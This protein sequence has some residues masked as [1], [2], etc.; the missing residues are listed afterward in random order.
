[1]IVQLQSETEIVGAV[2]LLPRTL[3]SWINTQPCR[4]QK[5]LSVYYCSSF[6]FYVLSQVL[7]D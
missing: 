6:F 2:V 7:D 4:E 5:K 1:M 3:S